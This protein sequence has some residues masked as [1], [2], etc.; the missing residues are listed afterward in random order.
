MVEPGQGWQ[1]L[2]DY[3][4]TFLSFSPTFMNGSGELEEPGGNVMVLVPA[5]MILRVQIRTGHPLPGPRQILL[6]IDGQLRGQQISRSGR[7]LRFDG[8]SDKCSE[9]Q[10]EN[11][12]RRIVPRDSTF[13]TELH[14][15]KN[16]SYLTVVAYGLESNW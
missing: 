9:V 14:W 12:P 10:I 8:T 15:M 3:T 16:E 5:R 2:T 1:N 4:P 7:C 13:V 11:R 6:Y